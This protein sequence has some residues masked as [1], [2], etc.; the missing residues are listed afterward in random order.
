MKFIGITGG[1]GAGKSQVLSF[2]KEHYKCE[3]LLADEV[4]HIV[5]KPG[6]ECYQKLV[7]V[8]GEEV[9]EPSAD[10]RFVIGNPISKAKMAEKIFGSELLLK[11]VNAIVHPAVK[12]YILEQVRAASEKN[13]V[14]LFFLE[15]ALLIEN[16]Y[17]ALVDE[18]W[19]VY[20]DRDTRIQRL[21]ES[22]GY[23]TEKAESIIAKQ[24][25][26]KDYRDNSDFMIDNSGEFA[27]TC[28]QIRTKLEGYVWLA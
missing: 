16:G 9:L 3:I 27:F 4:A 20:A 18:M 7:A 6:T 26:D 22:R 13:E 12:D 21:M 11:E 28:Q 17:Q 23:S 14:E 15:A 10:G 8:L 2:L 1:I 19:Y 25:S 5:K 24:L